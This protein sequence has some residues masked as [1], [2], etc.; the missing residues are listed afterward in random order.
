[1]TQADRPICSLDSFVDCHPASS[2]PRLELNSLFVLL[3]LPSEELIMK[4][5]MSINHMI[6]MPHVMNE[7]L[8]LARGQNKTS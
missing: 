1:M 8:Q 6:K 3:S 2:E 4:V 5:I 7:Y